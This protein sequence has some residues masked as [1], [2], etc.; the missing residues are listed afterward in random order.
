MWLMAHLGVENSPFQIWK[1]L[2]ITNAVL[3]GLR[4]RGTIQ[5]VINKKS[6]DLS[7]PKRDEEINR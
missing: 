6:D 4:S 7:L 2:E 3:P 1:M 5:L